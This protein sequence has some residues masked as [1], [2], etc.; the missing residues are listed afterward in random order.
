MIAI[1]EVVGPETGQR[2]SRLLQNISCLSKSIY[3]TVLHLRRGR[4]LFRGAV[5][6]VILKKSPRRSAIKRGTLDEKI[7][8]TWDR[9]E[10][11]PKGKN[12]VGVARV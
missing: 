2:K 5:L 11:N 6:R 9:V 8:G 12:D 1:S 7:S 10:A 3:D 4:R